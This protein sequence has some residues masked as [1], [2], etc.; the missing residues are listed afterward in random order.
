[1][2]YCLLDSE[3]QLAP[4]QSIKGS[5][6]PCEVHE[7]LNFG[8]HLLPASTG[9]KMAGMKGSCLQIMAE[10]LRDCFPKR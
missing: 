3:H 6:V 9:E 2:L 10:T 7:I 1:M 4:Q 5:P 8:S